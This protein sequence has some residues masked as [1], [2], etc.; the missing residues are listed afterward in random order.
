ML[1]GNYL[2]Y[3]HKLFNYQK[4]FLR[5]FWFAVMKLD[6]CQIEYR[7]LPYDC[8]LSTCLQL[9]DIIYHLYF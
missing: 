9:L 7:Y 3:F 1:C 8:R 2:S 6:A 4:F 5:H